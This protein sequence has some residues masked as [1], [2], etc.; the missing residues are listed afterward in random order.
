VSTGGTA[1][2]SGGRYDGLTATVGGESTPA[3]GF[4]A[5]LSRLAEL[6]ANGGA[7]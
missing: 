5:S 2:I 4:A 7:A 3:S 6:V 1:C